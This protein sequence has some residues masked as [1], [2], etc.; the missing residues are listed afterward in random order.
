ARPLP[1]LFEDVLRHVRGPDV[2]VQLLP[3]AL[4]RWRRSARLFASP[5]GGQG[6]EREREHGTAQISDGPM[7]H[8]PGWNSIWASSK[9]PTAGAGLRQASAVFGAGELRVELR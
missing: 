7:R 3:G 8:H 4:C 9:L 1:E 5:A 2:E 6:E